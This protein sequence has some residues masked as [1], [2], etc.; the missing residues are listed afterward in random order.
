MTLIEALEK[1]AVPEIS[2]PLEN[3]VETVLSKVFIYKD[4]VRKVYKHEKNFIGD[5]T[6][7]GFR[8]VFYADDFAWNQ[9]MSPLVYRALMGLKT[10]NGIWEFCDR[11]EAEDYLIEMNRI[12]TTQDMVH[13][14]LE[15]RLTDKMIMDAWND[16]ISRTRALTEREKNILPDFQT[17]WRQLFD[18]RLDEIAPWCEMS[19]DPVLTS[20]VQG[21]ISKIRAAIIDDPYIKNFPQ[22]SLQVL[23]DNQACNLIFE[24]GK[25]LFI[26]IF[27][28]KEYWR[29]GD[30]FMT[31]T[32]MAVDIVALAGGGKEKA[33]R[34]ES[35][36]QLWVLPDRVYWSYMLY[37]ALIMAPYFYML[38]RPDIASKYVDFI[39]ANLEKVR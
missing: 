14:A 13:V 21:I 33:I 35:Q 18:R 8:R 20:E 9:A 32:R 28:M 19:H 17:T 6:D 36:K 4:I 1:N 24:N 25:P 16:M 38:Q 23:I 27:L 5:F 11:A 30:P 34:E 39:H 29:V 22:Q 15:G 37:S 10:N 31:M 26:D 7:S 3:V 12:D 2:A